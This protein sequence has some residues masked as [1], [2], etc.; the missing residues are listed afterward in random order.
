MSFLNDCNLITQIS[1]VSAVSVT[2]FLSFLLATQKDQT[3][4]GGINLF[5]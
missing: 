5:L 4:A 3:V 2:E 1:F